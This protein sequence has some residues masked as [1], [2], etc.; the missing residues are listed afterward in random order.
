[1]KSEIKDQWIPG[2]VFKYDEYYIK[3]I[4]QKHIYAARINGEMVGTFLIRWSDKEIWKEDDSD[5]CYIHHLAIDRN[6]PITS[7]GER[8]HNWA[9]SKIRS[10]GKANIRLDCVQ[11]N[12]RLNQYYLDRDYK[13]VGEFTYYDGVIGNLF[14]KSVL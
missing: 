14:E 5:S 2:E 4:E 12:I 10:C 13:L 9:E 1:M 3:S 6:C 7:L 11:S 8:L